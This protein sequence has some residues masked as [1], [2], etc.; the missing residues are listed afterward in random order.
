[1]EWGREIATLPT[2]PADPVLFVSFS[3][4]GR[5]L[6]ANGWKRSISFGGSAEDLELQIGAAEIMARP[7]G[8]MYP[9]MGTQGHPILIAIENGLRIV[10]LDDAGLQNGA[11]KIIRH[12]SLS[13]NGDWIAT[14]ES[15]ALTIW[16]ARTSAPLRVIEGAGEPYEFSA[17][18]KWLLVLGQHDLRV[19]EVASGRLIPL[20]G[21]RTAGAW[22]ADGSLL[23][24]PL[25]PRTV[26]LVDTRTWTTV[27]SLQSPDRKPL[28]EVEFSP[29]GTQLIV[30]SE[31]NLV[32]VWDLSLIRAELR[33][34]GLD[35]DLPSLPIREPKPPLRA[36]VAPAPSKDDVKP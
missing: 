18:G 31:S 11:R 13:R 7:Q 25:S 33:D 17:D 22:S 2:F 4:D 24:V 1:M 32:D 21:R 27:A 30:A 29:D 14:L 15:G 36:T 35:W 16:N 8:E 23:G 6:F 12:S 9:I 10:E 20:F 28:V 3:H 26:Q 19:L 5:S 34:L